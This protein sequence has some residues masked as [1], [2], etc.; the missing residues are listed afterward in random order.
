MNNKQEILDGTY[1]EN[2]KTILKEAAPFIRELD[3][4]G[5]VH[6]LIKIEDMQAIVD[7]CEELGIMHKVVLRDVSDK[8]SILKNEVSNKDAVLLEDSLKED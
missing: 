6:V 4:G 3:D 1:L 7:H 8:D 5:S 2:V